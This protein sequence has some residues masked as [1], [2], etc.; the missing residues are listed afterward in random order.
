M[1]EPKFVRLAAVLHVV[2]LVLLLLIPVFVLGMLGLVA[3]GTAPFL[4]PDHVSATGLYLWAGM[5]VGFLPVLALLWVL[6]SLRAL[7]ARYRDGDVLT[8]QS[9]RLILQAGKGLI[10]L[11]ALKIA[12]QPVT[13]VL[14]S[15]QAPPG[16]REMSVQIGQAE[17][18]FLLVAGLLTL[19]GWAMTEAAR[20]ADENKAFI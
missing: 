2:S 5:A 13:S 3:L 17:I 1:K 6:D 4:V 8:V 15:W 7:F 14:L 12:V 16:Q 20:Q 10:W 11:A 18:G 9:A 19:I